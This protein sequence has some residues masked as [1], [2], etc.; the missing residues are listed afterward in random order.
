MTRPDGESPLALV[1]RGSTL[2]LLILH[3]AGLYFAAVLNRRGLWK[4]S[5]VAVAEGQR[6]F[7]RRFV[8]AATRF[9]GGLIK[10][11]QV[12][13]LRL[14]VLPEIVS[15]ELARLQDRVEPHPFHEIASQ[16]EA[17]LGSPVE[18]RFAEF[19]TCPIAAASLGQV[20]RARSLDGRELAV[21]VLYPGIERS[22]AV[23]LA[24]TRLGLW[25]FDFVAIGDLMEVYRQLR[26]TLLREMDYV[27]E[28]RAAEEIARNLAEDTELALHLRIP[29]IHWDL[30]T[31]RVLA[32]EYVEGAKINA[33]SIVDGDPA[34]RDEVV[35]WASRAFL[36]MMFRDGFFHCD[37]H[38]GNLLVCPDGRIGIVD[39]GMN[40]RISPA[41]LAAVRQNVLASV[42]RDT[43]QYAQSLVA[44]GI[45]EPEDLPA[46]RKLAA[47]A[48]D[49]AYFNLT[50]REMADLD[51]GAYFRSMRSSLADLR[52]FRLPD[53]LVM[54]SRA[55]SLLYGLIVE[56]APGVRPLDVVGPYV[57]AFLQGR[58]PGA[59]P[60]TPAPVP[61][62][63]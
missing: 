21:K 40:Q 31:R 50:P 43:E 55:L 45:V 61:A 10:L 4:R 37:P 38:P 60:A 28:G 34:R 35:L 2:L 47:L 19:E 26:A 14:D 53:G 6:R 46:A 59:E 3:A 5:D 30:T 48:F 20:H 22:V 49:P 16:I 57:L 41:I 62:T 11:G 54:W 13:S 32:M 56:L 23:D 44:A 42:T 39:F 33:P 25:L 52:S 17:E 51:F 18:E 24:M 29:A 36:H 9:R 27:C 7:A 15:E 63:A 12:A 8:A 1:R 58:S